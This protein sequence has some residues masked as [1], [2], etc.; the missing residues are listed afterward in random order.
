MDSHY[1]P[2]CPTGPA[3]SSRARH[4]LAADGL[5]PPEPDVVASAW[6][7]LS[8]IG[9]IKMSSVEV[10]TKVIPPP[11]NPS[12]LPNPGGW[13]S[14]ERELGMELPGDYK[15]FIARYGTGGVDGFLWVLNPFSK[16]KYL[17]LLDEG[18]AKLN[19]QRQFAAE[20]PRKNPYP[21]HPESNGLFPWSVTDNGDVLYWLCKGSPSSWIVVVCDS[22][23]VDWQEFRCSTSMFLAALVTRELI[24]DVFPE[25]FPSESPE[26]IPAQIRKR[27][28][29][30]IL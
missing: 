20:F 26:F 12:D 19:A 29:K 9:A 14:V 7:S 11:V 15:E 5:S 27:R 17:N 2:P 6:I 28:E 18:K 30:R 25:D 22:R 4:S 10:L 16:N 13:Q 3:P 1:S 21:L 8:S 24:V 23:A